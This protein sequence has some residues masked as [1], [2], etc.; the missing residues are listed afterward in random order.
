MARSNLGFFAQGMAQDI[1]TAVDLYGFEA[2]I[3]PGYSLL[4][5]QLFEIRVRSL[6]SRAREECGV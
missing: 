2:T 5:P 3:G 1:R 6:S 4:H